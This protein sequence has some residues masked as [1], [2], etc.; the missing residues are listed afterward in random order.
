MVNPPATKVESPL[1]LVEI[2]HF[3]EEIVA[4][5][6]MLKPFYQENFR[7]HAFSL[8]AAYLSCSDQ[9]A[10]DFLIQII[11]HPSTQVCTHQVIDFCAHKGHLDSFQEEQELF[12]RISQKLPPKIGKSQFFFPLFNTDYRNSLETRLQKVDSFFDF[13]HQRVDDSLSP[14][15]FFLALHG[16]LCG[17]LNLPMALLFEK[18]YGVSLSLSEI[19]GFTQ[20]SSYAITEKHSLDPSKIPS[21][22][23][24]IQD[25]LQEIITRYS[26]SQA[27]HFYAFHSS[28]FLWGKPQTL[29]TYLRFF[30]AIE[31][32]IG[33]LLPQHAISFFLR[34]PIYWKKEDTEELLKQ[35][36]TL[37][38]ILNK[39]KQATFSLQVNDTHL[40][41]SHIRE[42]KEALTHMVTSTWRYEYFRAPFSAIT[43][44]LYFHSFITTASHHIC[45]FPEKVKQ[46]GT[47]KFPSG[48][49]IHALMPFD[50]QNKDLNRSASGYW[51][52][53]DKGFFI[54]F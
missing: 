29:N 6:E 51:K 43:N 33:R 49:P 32:Y 42:I 23:Q 15:L 4:K 46:D 8:T 44:L 47:L 54:I 31:D 5:V 39:K 45:V 19:F 24:S 38:H 50:D 36:E 28:F 14:D 12:N 16:H 1:K 53:D 35:V 26:F 11:N 7:H 20:Y 30:K 52:Q 41:Q 27:E 37:M 2:R 13:Y 34:Y 18:T 10:W 17:S 40:S 22:I 21:F 9:H 25:P 48:S 3:P